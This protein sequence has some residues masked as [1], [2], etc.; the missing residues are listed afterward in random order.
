MIVC[1]CNPTSDTEIINA[2]KRVN[3]E[4]ELKDVLN[5]CQCCKSCTEE[6]HSLY[7]HNKNKK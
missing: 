7:K 1:I 2:C 5:I 4:A 6:I 3:S